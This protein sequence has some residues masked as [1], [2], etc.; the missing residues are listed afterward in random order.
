MYIF[1]YNSKKIEKELYFDYDIS[2][3]ENENEIN[4]SQIE[5]EI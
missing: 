3:K 1:D 5:N 4:I 2:S